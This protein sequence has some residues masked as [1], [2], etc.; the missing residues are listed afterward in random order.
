MLCQVF[1]DQVMDGNIE[2][3]CL[4]QHVRRLAE[5]LSHDRIQNGIRACDGIGRA[6]HTELELV[7]GKGKRRSPVP[8]RCILGKVRQRGN[9]RFQLPTFQKMRCLSGFY[10]LPDHVLKLFPKENGYNGRRRFVGSK[11]VIISHVRRALAEKIRMFIH[12]LDHTGK[13]QQKLDIFIGSVAGI[14]QIYAI[15]R[16]KRPV[17]M[18]PGTVY[19]G[20]GLLVKQAGKAMAS[21]YLFH[22]FHHKLIVVYRCVSHLVNRGKLMLGGSHLIV[23]GLGRY[24][25]LPELDIQILHISAYPLTDGSEVMILQFLSFRRRGAKQSTSRKNEIRSF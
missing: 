25:Q 3:L 1:F 16:G 18:L 9:P 4:F 14:Q 12:R 7:A 5:R 20:E 10:Q 11:P 24:P 22:G 17:I 13:H 21:R 8:V 6:H 23:L 2:I 15:I 19:P